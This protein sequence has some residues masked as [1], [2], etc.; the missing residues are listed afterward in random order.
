M[1][2]WRDEKLDA[3]YRRERQARAEQERE[4]RDLK[5]QK[6]DAWSLFTRRQSR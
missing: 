2:F 4:L 1:T 5:E 6:A 3:S